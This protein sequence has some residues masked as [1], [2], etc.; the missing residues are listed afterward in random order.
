MPTFEK[1]STAVATVVAQYQTAQGGNRD[2]ALV[3]LGTQMRDGLDRVVY[4]HNTFKNQRAEVPLIPSTT[5]VHV[6]ID[7]ALQEGLVCPRTKRVWQL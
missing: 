3:K 4:Y 5:P 2:A 7:N 1:A 6:L